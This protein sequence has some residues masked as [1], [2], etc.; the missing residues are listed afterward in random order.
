MMRVLLAVLV[1]AVLVGGYFAYEAT[2]AEDDEA[3]IE[4]NTDSDAGDRIEDAAEE[5][6][7]EIGDAAEE[8]ERSV[9]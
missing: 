5:V 1:L 8:V 7:D 2:T 6:G 4:I 3:L 9:E